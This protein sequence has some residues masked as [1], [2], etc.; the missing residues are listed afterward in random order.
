VT[1]QPL[2]NGGDYRHIGRQQIGPGEFS[3]FDPGKALA[4]TGPD[5]ARVAQNPPDI[6]ADGPVGILKVL[7]DERLCCRDFNTDL[8]GEFPLEAREW[9]FARLELASGKL[10]GAGHVLPRLA[11]A[12]QYPTAAIA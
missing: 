7:L 4:F 5:A 6:E 8:L 1:G 11:A 9:F 12:D 3:C 10:P 2:A